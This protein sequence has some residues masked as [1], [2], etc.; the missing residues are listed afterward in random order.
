MAGEFQALRYSFAELMAYM[1]T[2]TCYNGAQVLAE[3]YHSKAFQRYP[4]RLKH[5]QGVSHP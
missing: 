5:G 1:A 2:L 4:R 3:R